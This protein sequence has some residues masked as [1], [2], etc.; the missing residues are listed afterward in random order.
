[1][2]E[3]PVFLHY[4]G[5]LAVPV[6]EFKAPKV[7]ITISTYSCV[8]PELLDADK[9]IDNNNCDFM[10]QFFMDQHI[11]EQCGL[12][13]DSSITLSCNS[14]GCKQQQDYFKKLETFTLAFYLIRF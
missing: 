10:C 8:F 2:Q 6:I 1:M 5:V 14:L 11:Q 13:C 12:F 9:P 7:T 4:F 3:E